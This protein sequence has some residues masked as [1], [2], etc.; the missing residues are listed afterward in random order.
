MAVWAVVA[1]LLVL[2]LVPDVPSTAR[3]WLLLLVFGPPAYVALE[4][5]SGLMFNAETG[6][7]ISTAR[8]SL[9]RIA[10]ALVVIL[11]ALAPFAWWFLRQAD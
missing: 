9:S 2:Q 8:F 11:V 5:A 7:R 10:V 3:G 4:W 1:T 6:A